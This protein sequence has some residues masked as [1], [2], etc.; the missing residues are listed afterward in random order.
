ME[1]DVPQPILRQ[2]AAEAVRQIRR[3]DALAQ[4]IETYVPRAAK[5]LVLLLPGL[6]AQE[7]I[8]HGRHQRQRP[9]AGTGFRRV[10]RDDLILSVHRAAGHCVPDGEGVLFKVDGIP[11]QAHHLAAAQAIEGGQLHGH[12]DERAAHGGKQ[13]RKLAFGV[14]ARLIDDLARPVHLVRRIRRDQIGLDRVAERSINERVI[15]DDRVGFHALPLLN[16]ERLDV[17]GS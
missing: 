10:R 12:L 1:T 6:E 9:V 3:M 14:E 7:H 13:R 8:P 15:V 2:C 16:V 11:A 5:P 4:L 17:N